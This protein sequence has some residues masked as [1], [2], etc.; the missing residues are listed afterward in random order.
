[1][2]ACEPAPSPEVLAWFDAHTRVWNRTYALVF[3]YF[4]IPC[5]LC[6]EYFGGHEWWDR[7]GLSSLVPDPAYPHDA[8]RAVGICP[9]CTRTGHGTCAVKDTERKS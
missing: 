1:M 6:G 2:S 5:P 3:G 4:W 8:G 7:D 9:T